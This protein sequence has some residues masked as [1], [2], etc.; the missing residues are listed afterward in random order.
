MHSFEDIIF[1]VLL[2]INM[3]KIIDSFFIITALTI[4]VSCSKIENPETKTTITGK[5]EN[6]DVYP[7]TKTISVTIVDFRDKK[8]I[9]TDSIK[10]DGSFEIVFDLYKT[11][12]VKV[13]PIVGEIIIHPGETIELGIDFKDIGNVDFIGK[14]QK[15]NQDLYKYLN[16]N[17]CINN[18]NDLDSRKLN[19]KDFMKLCDSVKSNLISKRNDFILEVNPN[20]EIL[21]WTIEYI[22]ISYYNAL[23]YYLF[24]YSH[25]NKLSPFDSIVKY[26]I[27]HLD[28][29]SLLFTSEVI[30]TDSY[31]LLD[32]YTGIIAQ[33]LFYNQKISNKDS[34]ITVLIDNILI[35]SKNDLFKEYLLAN[36]F[37]QELNQFNL[38]TFESNKELLINN[39]QSYS[40]KTPLFQYYDKLKVLAENPEIGSNSIKAKMTNTSGKVILDSIINKN[41]GKVIYIDCWA[42]WCGPCKAEMP[43]SKELMEKLQGEK[44]EFVYLCIDSKE[45]LWKQTISI[46]QLDGN[47][48]YCDNKQSQDIRKGLDIDG[49]PYYILINKHGH[50][51]ESGNYLRPSNSETINKIKELL[52]ES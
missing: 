34:A 29:I 23:S 30:N 40:I 27:N 45:E 21:K 52:K 15:T 2:R 10:S 37:Y 47:H 33:K 20:Q 41:R 44:I 1:N 5:I 8:S 51:I 14:S 46:L 35:E 39:I 18:F 22:D 48:I 32:I 16:S 49:V 19:P 4:C 28:S 38:N 6:M 3:K 7:N 43:H 36:F 42:T 25:K 12:D 11:Q 24:R 26:Y 31:K 50:I 13:D 9:F 17:Y